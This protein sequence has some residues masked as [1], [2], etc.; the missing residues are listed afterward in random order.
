[1]GG[2]ILSAA[3]MEHR[4]RHHEW[5]SQWRELVESLEPEMAHFFEAEIGPRY[6]RT[7]WL[8]AISGSPALSSRAI[9]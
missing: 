6:T 5:V 2:S 1:M 9:F 7:F 8:A 3:S 4:F